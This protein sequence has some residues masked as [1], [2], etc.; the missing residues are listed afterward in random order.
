VDP[1]SIEELVLLCHVAVLCS[2]TQLC[3]EGHELILRGTSTENAFIRMALDLG[4]DVGAIRHR[5][6]LIKTRHRSEDRHF[7]ETLHHWNSIEKLIAVKGSPLEVLAMCDT[8]AL[9]GET[10]PL[11]EDDRWIIE[12]EN[13]RMAGD[14]LRVLGFAYGVHEDDDVFDLC[15]DLTWLGLIGMADPV[16]KGVQ[17]L[18]P[19]FHH[20]GID[21]IMITGDQSPTAYAIAKELNLSKG[22]PIEILDSSH[23]AEIESDALRAL[24]RQVHVFARVSP[25]NKL[26]IVQAL[27]SAG[28]V[29]AMTGGRDQTTDRPSRQQT[30]AWQWDVRGTDIAREVADVVLGDDNLQTMIVAVG[31]GRTIHSNIRNHFIF[32]FPPISAKSW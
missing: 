22:D 7:M 6:P 18:I 24:S 29:V 4:L 20:A 10:R 30:L 14:S 2:E 28:K 26:Q 13:E 12:R 17:E 25:A 11:S 5:H 31:H 32:S 8:V 27:Q 16:R 19:L 1:G 23:L 15:R 21:T 9:D 3:E